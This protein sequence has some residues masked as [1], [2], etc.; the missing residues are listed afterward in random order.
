MSG[1]NRSTHEFLYQALAFDT[2]QYRRPTTDSLIKRIGKN[3]LIDI[4]LPVMSET[5]LQSAHSLKKS[6]LVKLLA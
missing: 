4:T 5:W 2:A 3:A 6:D 1:D